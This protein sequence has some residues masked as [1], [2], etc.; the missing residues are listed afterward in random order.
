MPIR[1]LILTRNNPEQALTELQVQWQEMAAV[2]NGLLNLLPVTR[3][4]KVY[5]E[6]DVGFDSSDVGV[7][8]KS[9]DGHYWRVQISNAGALTTTDLG[10]TKP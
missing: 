6:D 3:S 2:V 4:G 1:N 10:T 8:L 5:S 9:P 7:I